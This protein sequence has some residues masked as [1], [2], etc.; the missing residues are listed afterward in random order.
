[1]VGGLDLGGWAKICARELASL[2][3]LP[4]PAGGLPWPPVD[5]GRTIDIVLKF[6]I[7]H[8]DQNSNVKV[9][10]PLNHL[11]EHAQIFRLSK[12]LGH[13][14]SFAGVSSSERATLK[15]KHAWICNPWLF[16]LSIKSWSG[17][18]CKKERAVQCAIQNFH[19]NWTVHWM[20]LVFC[21]WGTRYII[22]YFWNTYM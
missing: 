6:Q 21:I 22:L 17:P 20:A 15:R 9:F 2:C 19:C 1:M 8:W 4:L 3:C 11:S 18:I 16:R 14:H 13:F 7:R 5:D 12:P 10:W